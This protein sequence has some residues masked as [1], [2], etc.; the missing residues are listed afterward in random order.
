MKLTVAQK[1]LLLVATALTGLLTLAGS[2]YYQ[3]DKTYETTRYASTNSVPSYQLLMEIAQHFS[4]LRALTLTHIITTDEAQMRELEQKTE[5]T[6]KLLN[7]GLEK[8]TRD[9]CLGASCM[10]DDK[11]KQ[12]FE[13]LKTEIAAYRASRS[14]VA[15][16]SHQNKTQE[17]LA[18]VRAHTTPAAGKVQQAFQRELDYN[19][20]LAQQGA[21]Q[22]AHAKA[23][24]TTTTVVVA[25]LTLLTLA[26][27]GG[28]IVR[29]LLRQLGGEPDHAAALAN[30]IAQGDLSAQ[31]TVKAGDN[32]SLMAAMQRMNRTLQALIAEM[33]RMS[34]QHDLGDIDACVDAGKF[35]G[36]FQA[37]AKGVNDMVF[38]H[39]AVKKKAMACVQAFGEGNLDAPLEAF[40]GKKKFINDTI[41]Q[42]RDN[43]KRIVNE[44]QD[45]TAAANRGDFSIK[46]DLTGKQGFPKTLSELLNQLSDTVD[47]AFRDT[48]DVAQALEQGNLTRK[49]TRSYQGAFDQVK[50]SL[51]NTVEKLAQTIAEVNTT[52]ETI[53]SATNQVSA[54]AQSLSQASSEQAASVEET[55]ATIEQASTSI[56]QNTENA[57]IADGMSAEGS[58]KAGEG[59]VA[60]TQTVT[61]MKDIARK[62]SIIDDIAY[63]TNLL[64]LNAAIEAARAGEHGKGFAVVAAE[65]RKLAERSQIAAQEIGQLAVTSVSMAEKAGR[66]L[67]EI[68]PATKKT[69]DLVQE[70]T[71][72][73]E[74]QS[75]GM[76]QVNAAMVQL[77]Q[78]TQQN[79][80]ASEELAATAEEMSGQ[81]ANLQEIMGFFSLAGSAS[82]RLT[83]SKPPA[84]GKAAMNRPAPAAPLVRTRPHGAV[85]ESRFGRF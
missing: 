43:L 45:I 3:L 56:Q 9:G 77:N 54:T 84:P 39:I 38:A 52:A 33:N 58:K 30:Q 37:M 53:A 57:K 34:S 20:Q 76:G 27:L 64:A 5:Q 79:A 55:T 51:N 2:S 32:D 68:V 15:E 78:I 85:D 24:A 47:Q 21:E 35:Q 42:L 8:Y 25:L 59:G 16:L 49:V 12:L 36:A 63:Q 14:K 65:V 70:I 66:L 69:A 40:P 4:N 6:E 80:S 71:A 75:V 74:E 73:S 72:A 22:G 1:M 28:F 10:T 67:D 11:E 82:V 18:E 48:I 83:P 44:I 41:E 46:L 81:A 62:I 50:Q 60:V 17:A 19:A 31:I 29:S 13:A 26:G 7:D 23:A 61:A